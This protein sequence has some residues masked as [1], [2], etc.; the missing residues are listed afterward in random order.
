VRWLITGGAGYI[1]AH[2]TRALRAAGLET[3]V[4]DDLSSGYAHRLPADVPL[5]RADVRD[6]IAV[7]EAFARFRPHGVVHLAARKDVGESIVHPLRYYGANLD[8][9][10]SILTAGANH[11]TASMLFSSSAAVY[12]TP[13]TSPVTEDDP[14]VPDNPYGRTKLVGEW[15]LRDAASTAGFGWAALR[16]FNVAGAGAPELRDIGTTNLVPRLLRAARTGEP[17]Q[18]Y[19]GDWPTPDGSAIRDYVHVADIADAHA[20]A[21]LAL[22]DG[23]IGAEVLNVGRGEGT[24]VL[25]MITAIGAVTGQPL[26]Y[27][28]GPRRAGDPAEVVASADRIRERLGWKARYDLTDIVRSAAEPA[29]I[30]A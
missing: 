25:E 27:L 22:Q 1:G 13:W 20:C 2:V 30:T 7:T 11:H 21:A 24:S 3:V 19:G 15:M 26:P 4:L 23:E 9:L 18:V 14:T 10:R 12:G 8:G 28:V 16:Y 6:T 17:A 29:L 5:V